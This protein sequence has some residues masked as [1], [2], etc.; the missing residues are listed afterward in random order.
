M[1]RCR[2]KVV[3]RCPTCGQEMVHPNSIASDLALGAGGCQSCRIKVS[4]PRMAPEGRLAA[5]EYWCRTENLVALAA[6]AEVDPLAIQFILALPRSAIL[7]SVKKF[8]WDEVG[9]AAE[10]SGGGC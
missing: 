10:R 6:V 2:Q 1:K 3:A 9:Y 5:L 8:L 4:W 7:A